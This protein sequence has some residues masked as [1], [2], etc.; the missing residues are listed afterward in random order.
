MGERPTRERILDAAAELLVQ[1]GPQ[2]SMASIALEAGVAIG[3]MYNHFA[4]KDALI[5][6]VY[7][8]LAVQLEAAVILDWEQDL[9]ARD[10]FDAYVDH[11]IDFFWSDP[12]RAILFEILSSLP[13]VTPAELLSH[14]A[15]SAD[16]IARVLT[17]LAKEMPLRP[18]EPGQLAAFVGGAIRNT[19]KWRRL[20]PPPLT[21]TERAQILAMCRA[22]ISADAA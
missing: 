18:S 14:F 3:S 13:I 21:Q 9:S 22:A 16:Y 7:D 12:K 17:A 6:A 2:C 4:S 5:R 1:S 10:R 20:R 19:L 8:R 11:Y 15:R